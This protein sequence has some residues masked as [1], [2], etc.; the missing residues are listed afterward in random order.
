M[1]YNSFYDYRPEG[2]KW[3]IHNCMSNYKTIVNVRKDSIIFTLH[4]GQRIGYKTIAITPE[5][6]YGET[7][8]DLYKFTSTDGLL[9]FRVRDRLFVLAVDK[10]CYSIK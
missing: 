3:K 6:I 4:Y 10:E 5:V 7:K 2:G 9:L 1:E 8:D